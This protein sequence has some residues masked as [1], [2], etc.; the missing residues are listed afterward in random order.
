MDRS[1]ERGRST[2]SRVAFVE[3]DDETERSPFFNRD[4][5]IRSGINLAI[6]QNSKV[7]LNV[8]SRWNVCV[9]LR[10]ICVVFIV[11]SSK[12]ILRKTEKF[13]V[14]AEQG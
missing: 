5:N 4:F 8:I 3:I 7:K 2:T 10:S 1:V 13:N 6:V 11:S 9:C 14:I 12:T